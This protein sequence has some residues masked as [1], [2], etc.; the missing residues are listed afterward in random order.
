MKAFVFAHICGGGMLDVPLPDD[1]AAQGLAMLTC[2]AQDFQRLG[3]E[4]TVTLDPRIDYVPQGVTTCLARDE[5]SLGQAV[6]ECAH[7]SDFSMIIAPEFEHVLPHW[8]GLVAPVSRKLLNG[9]LEAIELCSNKQRLGQLWRQR[10]IR[11]P[12][13]ENFGNSHEWSGPVVVKPRCGAGCERTYLCNTQSSLSQ[14]SQL[15]NHIIQPYI[16]GL[17]ASVLCVIHENGSILPLRAGCQIIEI[18][19]DEDPQVMTYHGG[20]VPLPDDLERRAIDLGIRALEPIEGLVGFAG[21]DMV[22][23]D[24]SDED[25]AIEINPRVTM[26]YV[27]LRQ[28]CEGNMLEPLIFPERGTKLTWRDATVRFD[29]AGTV[30]RSRA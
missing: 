6:R 30:M 3:I 29:A 2:V 10:G 26:S 23:G 28:L 16:P 4:V 19:K 8:H 12:L 21:V 11:T 25:Y 5:N 27:G 20:E 18:S 22:L 17:P 14:L 1:L 24:S 9:T 7:G 15:G 13:A